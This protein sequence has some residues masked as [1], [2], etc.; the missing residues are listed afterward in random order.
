MRGLSLVAASGGNSSSR[1]AGLSPPQPLLL[2]STGCKRAGSAV[3]AHGPSCS[4]A[5]GILPD[6]GPNP[7]P[8]HWQA[9]SQPLRHQ[10]S[11]PIDFKTLNFDCF[12]MSVQRGWL[13]GDFSVNFFRD[14]NLLPFYN[15]AIVKSWLPST[16][17]REKFIMENL[18]WL[19]IRPGSG[20][21]HFWFHFI[22]QNSV[23][24]S[25]PHPRKSGKCSL[26]CAQE[27]EISFVVSRCHT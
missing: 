26:T 19:D 16:H 17:G 7:C 25:Q 22:G 15:F 23:T 24:W 18:R 10:G 20:E 14:T 1:C 9:D 27:R 21:H 8:P 3:V 6:Q 4:A 2:Q 11:P 13:R 5:C 12:L